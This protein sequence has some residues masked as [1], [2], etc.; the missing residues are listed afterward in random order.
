MARLS[1]RA[2]KVIELEIESLHNQGVI[3]KL[4]SIILFSRL[5]TL[6]AESGK[7]LTRIQ[8]WDN[9]CDVIPDIDPKVL[10]SVAANGKNLSDIRIS[11]GVGV[12]AVLVASTFGMAST[13]ASTNV[14]ILPVSQV[15]QGKAE[16]GNQVESRAENPLVKPLSL[17]AR[18]TKTRV[19]A[20]E[21][22]AFIQAKRLGWQAALKGQNPPHSSQHWR[23]TAALWR[24]AIVYLNQVPESYVDYAAV[25]DKIAFYQRNLAE[26]EGRR[27]AAIA[28]ENSAQALNP[29]PSSREKVPQFSVAKVDDLAIARR[30]GWQAALASQS[31]PYPAQK[32]VDISHLWK[33]ALYHLEQIPPNST[34]YAEAQRIKSTYQQNLEAVRQRYRQEQAASQSVASLQ[35]ALNE[36]EQSGLPYQ[37]RNRQNQA[38]LT[39]LRAIPTGTDAYLQAQNAIIQVNKSEIG[40]NKKLAASY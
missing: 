39:K 22:N 33:T 18:F 6:Q 19:K 13:T 7:H 2:F 14:P 37:A 29:T 1:D 21:S 28:R 36:I 12:T 5:Q 26:V 40:G 23:E 8:I 4:D 16:A 3:D 31:A 11:A 30:H 25:E 17:K 10:T 27:V 9:L 15:S 38:I 35:A 20:S 34:Q 24:Q 32:W